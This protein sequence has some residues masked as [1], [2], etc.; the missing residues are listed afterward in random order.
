MGN[1]QL[2]FVLVDG[3]SQFGHADVLVAG[4]QLVGFLVRGHGG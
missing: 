2:E 4:G 3:G 1:Y